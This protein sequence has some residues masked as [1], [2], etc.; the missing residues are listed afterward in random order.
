MKTV[1]FTEFR[2]HASGYL[3]Q[4]EQGESYLVMRHG[5][6]VAEICPVRNPESPSPSWKRPALRLKAKGEALSAIIQEDRN[7]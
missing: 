1:S 4:V 5:R 3:T 2:S 7:P 6:P